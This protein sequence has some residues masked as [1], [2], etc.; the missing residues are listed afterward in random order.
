MSRHKYGLVNVSILLFNYGRV[1][2]NEF[3]THFHM[4]VMISF[5]RFLIFSINIFI[6]YSSVNMV[7]V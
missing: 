6:S 4:I 1:P 2:K 5:I 3:H 7:V